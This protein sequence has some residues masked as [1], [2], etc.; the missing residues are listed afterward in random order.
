M[1]VV[2]FFIP[3]NYC[4]VIPCYNHSEAL[5]GV[6]KHL[7]SYEINCILVD[8]GSS[9]NEVQKMDQIIALFPW[10]TLLRLKTNQGKGA[11]VMTGLEYAYNQGYAYAI[12]I[13]ADG[14]HDSQIVKKLI[15]QSLQNPHALISGCPIYD[16]SVP[17]HRLIARYIT[18]FWVWIETLSF[19][20]KDSMCGFRVYPLQATCNLI[21][22]SN[23]G[24]RMDFDTDI[25]VQLYWKGIP[26]IFVPTKVTYPKD[27][28]SHF[29]A[30]KDNLLITKMHTKLFLGMLPRIL[31]L[32]KRNYK[33]NDEQIHW[34]QTQERKGLFG[35]RLILKFY[36]IFGRKTSKLIM[37]P[38]ITYFWLTGKKQR[39]ASKQYIE[40]ISN[41]YKNIP[42]INKNQLT[43]FHHFQ[44]FG[45]SFLDK[46]ACWQG[47]I[48]ID[49]IY[50][51]NMDTY[52]DLISN[53]QGIILICSHLG[54]VEICR[55]LAQLSHNIKIN[56]LVFRKHA[57]RF[58]QI[59]KETNQASTFNL[60]QV[61]SIGAD[62]A[63]L[64]K[65][66]L[67]QGEWVAI[68]G[69]RTSSNPHQR[70]LD[71]SVSWADFL[72]KPAP[73]PKGPFILSSALGV[74]VY[75]AW[76]L[77]PNG[78]FQIYFEHFADKLKI[79]RKNRK[80]ELDL[81]IQ[82]YAKRLEHYCL[83]SPLDWFNFYDFW[84]FT[85]PKTNDIHISNNKDEE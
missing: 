75:L 36:H 51:P 70:M 20:I 80:A 42:L 57:A 19:S 48:K 56:T 55:A 21:K 60:I 82:N 28:I 44:R 2:P 62:T 3:S 16:N 84:Q 33:K 6:L 14:Q 72:G 25:M 22:Q 15:E 47:D 66:K 10:V 11:A 39:Q 74:P 63:I 1:S 32:I 30:F 17:K 23:I 41:Y 68:V 5:L 26:S 24:K 61:D 38:V 83:L 73:F 35:I 27:G 13:D 37:F 12:Q 43:S 79:S 64:L 4:F 71:E 77:K 31:P 53:K 54:D 58:N 29:K 45:E 69:D 40:I 18:H 8:D 78:R 52:L 34:S 81:I 76:G 50:S 9:V 49:D 59:L 65:Q 46:I 7:A 85:Q 67:E